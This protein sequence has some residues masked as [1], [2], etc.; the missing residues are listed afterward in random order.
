MCLKWRY[1]V[2]SFTIKV[3]FNS[4]TETSN[5]FFFKAI[6]EFSRQQYC[7][8]VRATRRVCTAQPESSFAVLP[9]HIHAHWPRVSSCPMYGGVVVGHRYLTAEQEKKKIEVHFHEILIQ[10]FNYALMGL[11]KFVSVFVFVFV[12][13]LGKFKT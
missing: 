7:W 8:T 6:A 2:F 11:T 9:R 13:Q 5:R 4:L 10:S 12:F 1:F 3:Q